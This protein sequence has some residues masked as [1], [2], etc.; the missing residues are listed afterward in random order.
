[1]TYCN[2]LVILAHPHPKEKKKE[3][4]EE[5]KEEVGEVIEDGREVEEG[6]G[7]YQY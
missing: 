2:R 1:M 6:E 3:V 7:V 4:V 5:E